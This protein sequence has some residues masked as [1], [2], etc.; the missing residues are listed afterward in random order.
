MKERVAMAGTFTT[1]GK[2]V[3]T[4]PKDALRITFGVIWLIDATLK[5]L[6]GFRSGYLA[7]ISS[8]GQGQP[9]WL[10]WWFSFWTNLQRP[11]VAFFAYSVAAAETLIAVAVIAGFARK[12][13]YISAAAL[14]VLIWAVAEGFG[15]P[16][17][18]GSSDIGTAII[19]AV[20]FMGLLA[21]MAYSG[22]ARY[23][24]DYY[25]EKKISWWWRIAEIGRPV[26]EQPTSVVVPEQATPRTSSITASLATAGPAGPMGPMGPMGPAGP[27]GPAAPPTNG[28]RPEPVTH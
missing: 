24:A 1:T 23:S 12:I 3:P 16:Y 9:G 13:T 10:H 5:W 17:T 4:W 6:P 26:Q 25:L 14:S 28:A 18:S 2:G 8:A 19:Y 20:V 15:G 27:A 7:M 11:E 22:P 21:L